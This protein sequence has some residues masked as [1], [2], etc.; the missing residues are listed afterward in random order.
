MVK[1]AKS[2]APAPRP[3][4]PTIAAPIV[5]RPNADLSAIPEEVARI[6]GMPIPNLAMLICHIMNKNVLLTQPVSLEEAAGNFY[7]AAYMVKEVLGKHAGMQPGALLHALEHPFKQ[8]EVARDLAAQYAAPKAIEK[9]TKG[10]LKDMN[11]IESVTMAYV[12]LPSHLND[13]VM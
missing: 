2:P 6:K 11:V 8:V 10:E 13:F 3:V 4:R 5:R 12:F 1:I 9:L 7:G